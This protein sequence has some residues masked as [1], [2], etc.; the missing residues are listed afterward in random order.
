MLNVSLTAP[1]KLEGLPI[2]KDWLLALDSLIMGRIKGGELK[3][4]GTFYSYFFL[5]K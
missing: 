3:V 2:V 5:I 1:G 4:S